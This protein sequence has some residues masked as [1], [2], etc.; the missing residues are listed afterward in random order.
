LLSALQANYNEKI[1]SLWK[2]RLLSF[3]AR[4]FPENEDTVHLPGELREDWGRPK[5]NSKVR[6]GV[7]YVFLYME[8][9]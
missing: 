1:A 9:A 3:C 5:Y 6:F 2:I 8:E 7:W 4:A